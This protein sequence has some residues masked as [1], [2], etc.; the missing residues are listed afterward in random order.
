[1]IICVIRVMQMIVLT[2]DVLKE[3]LLSD[4]SSL[5]GTIIWIENI[6]QVNEY[7]DADVFIDLLFE[8]GHITILQSLLPKTIVINSVERTLAEVNSSFV[9][10]NAW[11]GFLKSSIIEASS[12]NED[13]KQI[14]EKVFALFGKKLEWLPDQ[15]GFVTP[16]VISMVINEAF[17]ALKEGVSTKDEIDTAMKLGTNYPYGPF[18]WAE[19]IGMHRIDSLLKRL[20]KK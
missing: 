9:R 7:R 10:I 20:E 1:M 13:N 18:E 12:M 6:R 3:E 4:A 17:I 5:H 11:P 2:N 16:R 8:T 14:A 15:T 19:I